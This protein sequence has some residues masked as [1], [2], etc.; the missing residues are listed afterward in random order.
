MVAWPPTAR[1]GSPGFIATSGRYAMM[2]AMSFLDP[3]QIYSTTLYERSTGGAHG[4]SFV[5]VPARSL[6]REDFQTLSKEDLS[7]VFGLTSSDQTREVSDSFLGRWLE[8]GWVVDFLL[9]NPVP[10]QFVKGLGSTPESRPSAFA[11]Y[12]TRSDVIPFE[13]S[14]LSSKS[15]A[16]VSA[17]GE[18]AVTAIGTVATHDPLLLLAVPAGII[19][20]GGMSTSPAS[21]NRP[22]RRSPTELSPSPICAL[23]RSQITANSTRSISSATD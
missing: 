20:C 12:L 6:A 15:L 14:P 16:Q 4:F 13:S 3:P 8:S 11:V 19:I 9:G 1:S 17:M 2:C 23:P 18:G 10:W 22:G 21:A 7:E 5:T